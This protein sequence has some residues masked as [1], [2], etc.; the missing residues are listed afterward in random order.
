MRLGIVEAQIQFFQV[1]G[2]RVGFEFHQIGAAV[3]DLGDGDLRLQLDP[4]I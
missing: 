1:T 4:G 2:W 3:T